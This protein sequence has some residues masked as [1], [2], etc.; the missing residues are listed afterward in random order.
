MKP[1]DIITFPAAI[2]IVVISAIVIG[3]CI[4]VLDV[5]GAGGE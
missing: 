4:L 2:A 3:A 1:S 5:C